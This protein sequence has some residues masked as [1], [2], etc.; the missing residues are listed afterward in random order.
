MNWPL[1]AGNG[2]ILTSLKPPHYGRGWVLRLF[3]PTSEAVEV[4]VT[5]N[6]RPR[7]VRTTNLAEDSQHIV[8]PD[9]NGTINVTLPP[10]KLVTLR[11]GFG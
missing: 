6:V 9:G 7:Y 3:N 1:N 8:E 10:Q 11:I 4:H 5:P 2:A